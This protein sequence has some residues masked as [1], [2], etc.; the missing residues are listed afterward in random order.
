ML[1]LSQSFLE[2]WS[3]DVCHKDIGTFLGEENTCL[4]ANTTMKRLDGFLDI[5]DRKIGSQK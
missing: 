1:E 4:E 5:I 3:R 2:S